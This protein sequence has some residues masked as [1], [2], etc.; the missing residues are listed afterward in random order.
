MNWNKILKK[1]NNKVLKNFGL[2][3]F[4]GKN[5]LDFD[6]VPN[7]KDCQPY[8]TMRQDP[9]F[10][11]RPFR[12]KFAQRIY[13]SDSQHKWRYNK[14]IGKDELV[15]FPYRHGR[16]TGWF[17]TGI[18]GFATREQAEGYLKEHGVHAGHMGYVREFDIKN[19]LKMDNYRSGNLH[20]ASQKMFRAKTDEDIKDV[21]EEFWF[22]GLDVTEK[23]IKNAK[24]YS[25]I[26]GEQPI[27]YLLKKKGYT[28]VI[29][30]DEYQ[31]TGYGSVMFASKPSQIPLDPD[32]TFT[33][34]DLERKKKYQKYR[35]EQADKRMDFNKTILEDVKDVAENPRPIEYMYITD[36]E[37]ARLPFTY[38]EPKDDRDSGVY[39]KLTPE[40]QREQAKWFH[41]EKLDKYEAITGTFEAMDK[42]PEVISIER[43]KMTEEE[44]QELIDADEA[45]EQYLAQEEQRIAD[46]HE[47]MDDFD[48]WRSQDR[49]FEAEQ[50]GVE[51]D[52]DT[53]YE[54][55]KKYGKKD[56]DE[57]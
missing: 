49:T 45:E 25:K 56:D 54:E 30:S 40:E 10:S 13:P 4:G 15:K 2:K 43:P 1:K 24:R 53:E 5:D 51:S 32:K 57:L 8:N 23:E 31:N 36:K 26:S 39:R 20:K 19:P 17:G 14:E 12:E 38:E 48:D 7:K 27:N 29:P 42:K 9:I 44:E 3:S 16:D 47:E 41:R 22:A 55:Y 35:Q 52:I 18:Y 21:K 50:R 28:G 11:V 34:K 33:G 46:L 37:K 6:G